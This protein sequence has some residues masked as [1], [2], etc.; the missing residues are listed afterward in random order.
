M[1]ADGLHI[2]TNTLVVIALCLFI[3]ICVLWLFGHRPGR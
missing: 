3:V 1:L 2:S